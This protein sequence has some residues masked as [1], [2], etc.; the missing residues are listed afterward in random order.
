MPQ[1]NYLRDVLGEQQNDAAQ[2]RV[3]ARLTLADIAAPITEPDQVDMLPIRE[4]VAALLGLDP[5]RS[6]TRHGWAST[7]ATFVVDGDARNLLQKLV[8]RSN[9]LAD[10]MKTGADPLPVT[11]RVQ[12]R[13]ALKIAEAFGWRTATPPPLPVPR[14]ESQD[15]R[16]L[17]KLVELGFEPLAL[18]AIKRGGES[19]AKAAIR[20]AFPEFSPG[21]VDKAW[22]RLLKPEDG[23]PAKIKNT[24][25]K[26]KN[27]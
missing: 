6:P 19:P 16:I 4:I 27:T 9:L 25:A 18:P 15:Q 8:K 10:E 5:R 24:P 2:R 23:T 17:A 20:K 13:K 14:H 1:S 7:Y 12:A 26:I 11:A 3:A 21:V 22:K